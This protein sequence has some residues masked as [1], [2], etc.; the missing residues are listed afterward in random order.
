MIRL[1]P[2]M[3]TVGH[4]E[5]N[6]LC[7]YVVYRRIFIDFSL[8]FK[9]VL[10]IH[11]CFNR[12]ILRCVKYSHSNLKINRDGIAPHPPPGTAELRSLNFS[13]NKTCSLTNRE[14][15]VSVRYHG[16]ITSNYCG[17]E[18]TASLKCV[19]KGARRKLQV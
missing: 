9:I 10:Q 1:R 2:W 12:I 3:V 7:I 13:F 5:R 4:N 17:S 15:I 8:K 14:L 11:G 6:V 18:K 19:R 16:Q